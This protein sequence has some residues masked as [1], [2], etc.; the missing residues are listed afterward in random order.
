MSMS[1]FHEFLFNRYRSCANDFSWW[2]DR[3]KTTYLPDERGYN[4]NKKEKTR[5]ILTI[6]I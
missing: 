5:E 3:I 6:Y 4:G 2:V 1:S